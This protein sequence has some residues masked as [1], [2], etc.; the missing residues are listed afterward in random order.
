MSNH[1]DITTADESAL[2]SLQNALIRRHAKQ[3]KHGVP[4]IDV[5]SLA[6]R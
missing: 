4:V 6:L 1:L 5:H 3:G 2:L